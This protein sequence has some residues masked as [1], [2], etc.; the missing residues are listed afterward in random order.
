MHRTS[1][2]A[3]ALATSLI[4]TVANAAPPL[5]QI[6]AP[7]GQEVQA[8]RDRNQ[9]IQAPRDHAEDV[10]AP[11]ERNEDVQAPRGHEGQAPRG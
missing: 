10:R 6:Q 2:L 11:R 3:I 4:A 9:D 7:R 8:P 5:A 1:A